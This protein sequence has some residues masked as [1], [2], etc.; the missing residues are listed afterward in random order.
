MQTVE[1][2]PHWCGEIGKFFDEIGFTQKAQIDELIK[3]V[4]IIQLELTLEV[5]LQNAGA[6]VLQKMGKIFDGISNLRL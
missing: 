2:A 4:R 1:V 3:K 6:R 5:M